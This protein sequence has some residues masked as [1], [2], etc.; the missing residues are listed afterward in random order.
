MGYEY[1]SPEEAFEERGGDNGNVILK[2]ILER[3]MNEFNYFT[4]DDKKYK[5]SKENIKQAIKDLD[6]P[7]IN[8]YLSANEKITE[9]LLKGEGYKEKA[10]NKRESFNIRYIDFNNIENNAFHILLLIM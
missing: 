4:Y 3:Q 6:V 5:F 10:G 7:L 1:L 9:K 8:G 2:N